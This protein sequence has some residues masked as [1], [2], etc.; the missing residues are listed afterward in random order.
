MKKEKTLMPE[1]EVSCY[2]PLSS[3]W[4]G[5]DADLLEAMLSFYPVIPPD[6]I[7]D[8]TYNTGRMWKG[9]PRKVVSMDIDPQYKPD[10]FGDNR[11]MKGVK[12][13]RFGVVVYDPPHVGP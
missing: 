2:A 4:E 12:S 8:A 11:E 1:H 6:P 7:L 3:V 5:S 13:K 10:I 9:L